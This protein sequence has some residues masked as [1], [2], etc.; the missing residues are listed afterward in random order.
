MSITPKKFRDSDP[1]RPET[2]THLITFPHYR[3]LRL[4]EEYYFTLVAILSAQ[5]FY[6]V[7]IYVKKDFVSEGEGAGQ[8]HFF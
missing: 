3:T 8:R 5:T 6:N 4:A 7:H 1:L 2:A